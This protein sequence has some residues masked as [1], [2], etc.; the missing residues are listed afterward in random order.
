MKVYGDSQIIVKH[1]RNL[2]HCISNK[3][4]R[5]QQ[6]IWDLLPSFSSFNI[7]SI[8]RY[9]NV[10]ADLLANIDSH[11]IPFENFEPNAFSVEL[12]YMPSIP[13]NVTN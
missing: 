4:T 10:D 5:Y 11:L 7:Y 9:L 1:V 13:D 3:L 8:P 6:E 2:I 12:M